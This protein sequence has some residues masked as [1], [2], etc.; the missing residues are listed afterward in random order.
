MSDPSGRIVVTYNG[1]IY[2]DRQLRTEL[3]REFGFVFRT[4][5]DT[6]IL[7]YA[8][9]AWG[10]AMFERIEGMYAVGLWDCKE[11]RLL[12]ARDGIGIKP[13]YFAETPAS[14]LFASEIKA[15]LAHGEINAKLSPAHL[16]TY[17]AAGY[18]GPSATLLKGVE[19]VPPGCVMAFS[20]AGRRSRQF[21]KP[22]RR[23]DFH[24]LEQAVDL[25]AHT[26]SD[27]VDEQLISD[28]PLCVLQ[29][30]GIDSSLISLSVARRGVKAPLFT[31]SFAE[32]SHDETALAQ[33]VAAAT[34][35]P[36]RI[37]SVD[38]TGDIDAAFRSVV[39]HFDGQCADTGALAFYRLSAAVRRHS[40]VALSGDGGDEFFC[41]YQTYGA[42]R[43][44]EI[45]RHFVP[46]T[47]AHAGGVLAYG[48]NPTDEGRLP[49]TGAIARFALGLSE[50]GPHAHLEWR[51]LLPG[52]LARQVYGAGME[53]CGLT[54]PY[55]EYAQDFDAA[56][57]SVLD[58]AMVADQRFHIQSVLMKV[59][60]MSMAHSLEVRVPLLD[61]RIM[62]LAGR[63][64]VQLLN[65]RGG[66]PKHL[67]RVLAR[68][69]GAP[70]EV[71]TERKHGFNVPIARLLR[72]DLQPLADQILDRDADVLTPY[73]VADGVRALWRAHRDQKANNAYALWPILT[74][75]TWRAGLARP[76][77]VP[78][79]DSDW[80]ELAAG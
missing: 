67:L 54:S 22:Q 9:L 38:T 19:Q 33:A 53:D 70:P 64:A 6:E 28:V 66:A 25:L 39:H 56:S 7:P 1:E 57:G 79:H 35:L 29:S 42:T 20:R 58:R 80:P 78:A 45:L 44:A 50:G 40:T 2:N 59:D 55:S 32:K 46:R 12:L 30:G 4:R 74:L 15:L 17:F 23:G 69:L 36:Q 21:W 71:T 72:N 48:L 18:A 62:E 43:F 34:G 63:M 68:R 24:E 60:A 16:H 8:Y 65:P 76:E 3:E 73:L 11:E 47:V 27:V 26:L 49:A 37:V 52:F 14:L 75:G 51:R 61:R 31:A 10:E 41:G 5:C 77:K 13:L